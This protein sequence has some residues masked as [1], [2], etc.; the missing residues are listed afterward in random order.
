MTTGNLENFSFFDNIFNL[1]ALTAQTAH[2]TSYGVYTYSYYFLTEGEDGGGG[3]GREKEI[4]RKLQC[5]GCSYI[6]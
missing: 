4:I 1:F 6:N 3:V 2:W 5:N